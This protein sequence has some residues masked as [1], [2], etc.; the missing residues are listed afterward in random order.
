MRVLRYMAFA[1]VIALVIYCAWG[2]VLGEPHPMQWPTGV[3]L[4][5]AFTWLSAYLFAGFAD[6]FYSPINAEEYEV[7]D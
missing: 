5:A 3:R 4:S 7:I 1:L 6:W 2:F